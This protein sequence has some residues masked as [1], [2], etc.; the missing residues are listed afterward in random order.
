MALACSWGLLF[1]VLSVQL[2][3]AVSRGSFYQGCFPRTATIDW[4]ET[5]PVGFEKH[6]GC[7][8]SCARQGYDY[9]AFQS[10][11]E[12]CLCGSDLVLGSGISPSACETRC[13]SGIECSTQENSSVYST[14]VPIIESLVLTPH[15]E[16]IPAN[17]FAEFEASVTVNRSGNFFDLDSVV[18]RNQTLANVQ[19]DW[20]INHQVKKTS[21]EFLNGTHLH[22]LFNVTV[23]PGNFSIC[24]EV[25][26]FVSKSERCAILEAL[27]CVEDLHLVDV[28]PGNKNPALDEQVQVKVSVESGSKVTFYWDFGDGNGEK[29]LGAT[30]QLYISSPSCLTIQHRYKDCGNYSLSL[31]AKNDIS[32]QR[33]AP[34]AFIVDDETITLPKYSFPNPK[35]KVYGLPNKEMVLSVDPAI[36]CNLYY[37]WSLGDGGPDITT[38]GPNITYRYQNISKYT[39]TV[40]VYNQ[41]FNKPYPRN[42]LVYIEPLLTGVNLTISGKHEPY[43][44]STMTTY[45]FKAHVSPQHGSKDA[46]NYIWHLKKGDEEKIISGSENTKHILIHNPGSYLVSVEVVN[47]VSNVTSPPF[48]VCVQHPVGRVILEHDRLVQL[49]EAVQYSA[50]IEEGSD[51]LLNWDFGDQQRITTTNTTKISHTYRR[52]GKYLVRLM[53]YNKINHVNASMTVFVSRLSSCNLQVQIS[54]EREL[55]VFRSSKLYLEALVQLEC[56]EHHKLLYNWTV[57]SGNGNQINTRGLNTTE[58][59]L[60]IPPSFLPYGENQFLVKVTLLGEVLEATDIK[61]VRVEPHGIVAVI[62]GGTMRVIGYRSRGNITLDG[63]DSYDPDYPDHSHQLS[64]EWL[65]QPMN[66]RNNNNPLYNIPPEALRTSQLTFPASEVVPNLEA[67]NITLTVS[68]RMRQ[69]KSKHAVQMIRMV[70]SEPYLLS[71]ECPQCVNG[72]VNPNDVLVLRGSCL[73]CPKDIKDVFFE[74]SLYL[75]KEEATLPQTPECYSELPTKA[76]DSLTRGTERPRT[77]FPETGITMRPTPGPVSG[78]PGS[79]P[80]T[81]PGVSGATV[82]RGDVCNSK[83]DSPTVPPTRCAFMSRF[84]D[85][86]SLD[87][88]NAPVTG[89]TNNPVVTPGSGWGSAMG[90]TTGH[91]SSGSGVNF[92]TQP[93]NPDPSTRDPDTS[94]TSSTRTSSTPQPTRATGTPTRPTS[95]SLF[96]P[97]YHVTVPLAT[98]SIFQIKRWALTFKDSETTTGRRARNLVVNENKLQPGHSYMLALR[99]RDKEAK[100]GMASIIFKVNELPVDGRCSVFPLTGVELETAFIVRCLGWKDKLQPLGY[101][102]SYSQRRASGPYRLLYTGSNNR[103]SV[104]L[105]SGPPQQDYKVY[106]MVSVYNNKGARVAVCPMTLTVK[107]AAFNN[108]ATIE[109]I[110]YNRTRNGNELRVLQETGQDH[111]VKQTLVVS[112]RMLNSLETV[113]NTTSRFFLRVKT[114]LFMLRVLQTLHIRDTASAIHSAEVLE[115]ATRVPYELNYESLQLATGITEKI[116]HQIQRFAKEN[117]RLSDSVLELMTR[118]AANLI[119]GATLLY[120]SYNKSSTANDTSSWKKIVLVPLNAV[121][122]IAKLKISHTVLGESATVVNQSGVSVMAHLSSVT[123]SSSMTLHHATFTLPPNMDTHL[124]AAGAFPDDGCVST[125]ATVYDKNPYIWVDSQQDISQSLGLTPTS[126]F[127]VNWIEAGAWGLTLK[128]GLEAFPTSG[129][130]VNR[131][132]AGAWGLTLKPGLEAFPTSGLTVNRIEA[133]AWGLTL[134]PGLEAFPTSGLTVNRIEAGAWGL[135]LQ[136]GFEA[137]PTSGLTVNRIEAGAWGLTLKPGFEAFPTSGLTV[138]RIE[139]AGLTLK[140]GLEAFPTSGLTVNRIEAGAWGLT[141]KPGFEAFPT[142]GLTV[143]RIEA[144]AWGLTLKPGFEAFPTSGLT[145]NRIEAGAWGLTLQPGFEAFPTSGLTVNRIEAGAWGLTLK[146]G[147]KAF[148]TSGLTHHSTVA[149]LG[150]STCQGQEIP[151]KNLSQDIMVTLPWREP[152]MLEDGQRATVEWQHLNVHT[153]DIRGKQNHSLHL[154]IN[155]DSHITDGFVVQLMLRTSGNSSFSNFR[156]LKATSGES[157]DL[158]LAGEHLKEADSAIDVG[159]ML[160]N[161]EQSRIKKI[162]SVT[163]VNYSFISHWIGCYYW[164][165]SQDKWLGDGCRT[166][167]QTTHHSV[168]CRCNHLTAFSGAIQLAPNPL[169]VKDL[170]KI[171]SVSENPVTLV[172]VLCLIVL[173]FI[174]L[175]FCA[176]ADKYDN[177]KQRIVHIAG[178]PSRM[179]QRYKITV[180]TG[181]WFGSGTTA[182]VVILLHG[183]NHSSDPIELSAHNKPVFERASKDVFIFSSPESLSPVWKIHIWHYNEGKSPSWYLNRV[184]IKDLQTQQKWYF[185][186]YRWLAVDEEDGQVD[187]ELLAT[188]ADKSH[189]AVGFYYT[190]MRG[191]MD[192]HLWLSVL[193]RP[194]YSRFTRAQRLTCCLSLL[195]SYLAANAAWYKVND[196]PPRFTR[197]EPTVKSLT[198]EAV[199]EST[200]LPNQLNGPTFLGDEDTLSILD[201]SIETLLQLRKISTKPNW[202]PSM[203]MPTS[204]DSIYEGFSGSESLLDSTEMKTSPAI[205]PD[206]PTDQYQLSY[207]TMSG[208]DGSSEHADPHVTQSVSRCCSV[209][210]WCTSIAWIGCFATVLLAVSITV[211]Y[212][213]SFGY[214]K[215][216]RWLQSLIFSI[217]ESLLL[218]QPLAVL[219]VPLYIACSSRPAS[220]SAPLGEPSDDAEVDEGFEDMQA[221]PFNCIVSS[222]EETSDRIRMSLAVRQHQRYLKF[223][224]PPKKAVLYDSYVKRVQDRTVVEY[225]CEMVSTLIFLVIVGSLVSGLWY[226][227]T[228][229]MNETIKQTITSNMLPSSN[230]RM[231]YWWTRKHAHVIDLLYWRPPVAAR[232]SPQIFL[233]GTQSFLV[234]KPR[235]LYQHSFNKQICDHGRNISLHGVNSSRECWTTC[236]LQKH[237]WHSL[238][239]SR[240]RSHAHMDMKKMLRSLTPCIQQIIVQFSLF[241]PTNNMSSTVSWELTTSLVGELESRVT[242]HSFQS[243]YVKTA[244]GVLCKI[245][246]VLFVVCY[247]YLVHHVL[248]AVRKSKVK[249]FFCFWSCLEVCLVVISTLSLAVYVRWSMAHYALYREVLTNLND[250]AFEAG[251][252]VHSSEGLLL[253]LYSLMV[254]L[255]M[256]RT[257][258]AF[259]IFPFMKRLGYVLTLASR[260]LAGVAVMTVVYLLTFTH[261]GYLLFGRLHGAFRSFSSAFLTVSGMLRMRGTAVLENGFHRELPVASTVFVALYLLGVLVITRSLSASVVR[262]MYHYSKKLLDYDAANFLLDYGM[263]KLYSLK[264]PKTREETVF[265]EDSDEEEEDQKIVPVEYA[266]DEVE[267]QMEELLFRMD[268]LVG[269]GNLEARLFEYSTDFLSSDEGEVEYLFRRDTSDALYCYNDDIYYHRDGVG[270]FYYHRDTN[271]DLYAASGYET[272]QSIQTYGSMPRFTDTQDDVPGFDSGA[273]SNDVFFDESYSSLPTAPKTAATSLSNAKHLRE[274]GLWMHPLRSTHE[275]AAGLNKIPHT[276]R[277]SQGLA[278]QSERS[279]S[280]HQSDPTKER[281]KG[282]R[283]ALTRKPKIRPGESFLDDLARDECLSEETISIPDETRPDLSTYRTRNVEERKAIKKTKKRRGRGLGLF[284]VTAVSPG[285]EGEAIDRPPIQ[286]QGFINHVALGEISSEDLERSARSQ[287]RL[288]GSE[289]RWAETQE[290]PVG[291]QERPFD[292]PREQSHAKVHDSRWAGHA[293]RGLIADISMNSLP[294]SRVPTDHDKPKGVNAWV[295]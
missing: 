96:D 170:R 217:V 293:P 17:T 238:E 90:L 51:L 291:S 44:L 269:A 76:T 40:V 116:N 243:S 29:S 22:V 164:N 168:H 187:V 150:L 190:C 160:K 270:D 158:F 121:N 171:E 64:Y 162:L 288:T 110:L 260:H 11:D 209:P 10:H 39:I 67:L 31:T 107:P 128:P 264:R 105:P 256:V 181:H 157:M 258:H 219:A 106:V 43:V 233:R 228:Y 130:T 7:V 134:K 232:E 237:S 197:T 184:I 63:S 50:D 200:M 16:R 61:K 19:F 224:R 277:N 229:S 178:V 113:K 41:F 15:F 196:K 54:G 115:D 286:L 220:P 77:T 109:E 118:L 117:Q 188:S 151:V 274:E 21:F 102:V 2:G 206:K 254:F 290:T 201:Q 33:L 95:D 203:L 120:D 59:T 265:N 268:N 36:G 47:G 119:T 271:D 255:L 280:R 136:P 66:G 223:L 92:P 272:D 60:I 84:N 83:I 250:N 58:P 207:Q 195:L 14:A 246:K 123:S 283:P 249:L 221:P 112:A 199:T 42:I 239:L 279:L 98:K 149:S 52:T 278:S 18:L 87:C 212:G 226:P 167:N 34:L 284:P 236:D 198:N 211:W 68:K 1:A 147:F 122:D 154:H 186:C 152:K 214:E 94:P 103:I 262:W 248:K 295:P 205:Y 104:I 247:V 235:I 85:F 294:Q 257:L 145:V 8:S 100:K 142:S 242:V 204:M 179:P 101:E 275:P 35:Y 91:I 73:T 24:L 259:R 183:E 216:I 138:N 139:A 132:E 71:I 287:E 88:T 53:V 38:T 218:S 285:D 210:H 32:L 281:A 182:N 108:S 74:W 143:N 174:L 185:N 276:R 191:L 159:V 30:S 289:E 114:R 81:G 56:I 129:L 4:E 169:H 86:R 75:V 240:D 267:T 241:T 78:F 251:E 230:M 62:K 26:N 20:K 82:Q 202:R 27:S 69:Q 227:G 124:K 99:V 127:T 273:L 148:P 125:M 79:L 163:E 194:S 131:I 213:L 215:S 55:Q 93:V 141:L 72:L 89:G 153:I 165:T 292:Q 111:R 37:N 189:S 70:D 253:Y 23:K 266:V 166:T 48:F 57:T 173:Y 137:F 175:I 25:S 140:P 80:T 261:P 156:L 45:T 9:A 5:D 193:G 245:C 263:I 155:V 126:G 133:G 3:L 208:C 13:L 6:F 46:K 252:V 172:L 231:D 177:R 49:D 244:L 12:G 161:A 28:L 135:T 97:N 146:P 144:G 192:Y 225:I 234:G 180:E 65:V 282:K 222:L 176:R